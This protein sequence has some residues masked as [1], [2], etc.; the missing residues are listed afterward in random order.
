MEKKIIIFGASN[1]GEKFV[2]QYFDKV[3]IHCFWDN[4]KSGELLGYPIQKPEI[5]NQCF[6]IV[7]TVF[8]WEIR[9][10]LIQ[11][12]YCEF[13]DFIPYQIFQKKIAITY[14]NCHMTAVQAYL[15]KNKEFSSKYG[16]YPFPRI[17]EI[18]NFKG[19]YDSALQRCDLFLHQ[20]VRKKNVYGEEFS[21][22][23]MLGYLSSK[24][25]IIAVPNLYGRPKYLFPQLGIKGKWQI[26]TF[27]PYFIDRN[28]VS[29]IESGVR[30]DEMKKYMYLGGT[31]KKA[32]IISMW[33]VFLQEIENREKEWDIKILDYI[34]LNQKKKKLFCDINHITSE[35][36][37]EIANRILRHLN[38]D[39]NDFIE[40]PMMDDLE[41]F[42]YADVKDALE[43]EFEEK[44]IRKW[45]K[46]NC[47]QTYEVN[48]DEYV[49]QLY[50]FTKFCINLKS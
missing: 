6:I 45:G 46:G 48:R 49:E 27:C 41:V 29:W 17:Y 24:C 5:Q 30:I 50:Q 2:Y 32:E 9:E 20:S 39:N 43:L 37:Y 35:T 22:E 1:Q 23:D 3:N 25:E 26:G 16:F 42:I 14:G 34:I 12:G 18:M 21:S 31:Y 4:N 47:L 28:V 19:K 40:I 13:E 11:M 33:E 38:Y 44:C 15:E 7:A 8:Y 10:Q 36:A